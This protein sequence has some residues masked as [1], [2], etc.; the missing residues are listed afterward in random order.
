MRQQEIVVGLDE[1]APAQRALEWA[2]QEARRRGVPLRAVHALTGPAPGIGRLA[3]GSD[4]ELS[5]MRERAAITH[6]FDSVHP[7]PDWVIQFA[8][9]EAGP[10]LVRQ[11]RNA[12]LLVLGAPEDGLLGRVLR[13]SVAHHCLAHGTAQMAFVPV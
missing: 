5:E 4:P 13:S 11:S 3:D 2:A 6:L 1:T 8:R 10:V 9:G 7:R 12:V